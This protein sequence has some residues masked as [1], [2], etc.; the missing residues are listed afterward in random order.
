MLRGKKLRPGT[1]LKFPGANAVVRGGDDRGVFELELTT[2]T[3]LWTWLDDVGQ[4]PLPPYIRRDADA[5]DRHR[6]QTV[7]AEKV[8]AVAAPTA[9]LHFTAD[10]LNR[11]RDKG[12]EIKTITLHVGLGTFL[13]MRV[14]DID[15]HVMHSEHYQVPEETRLALQSKRPVVAVGT[16]VVRAL[17]SYMRDP[18]ATRT[19]IFIRPGFEY[20]CVDGLLTNFHLPE[21]TLLMLVSAFAGYDTIFSAYRQAVDAQMRF[22]SYGDA[23]LLRR[24]N[25]R[26]T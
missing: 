21:S 22:F 24:R 12:V 19:D 15:E 1:D 9:G 18:D 6:Y 10:L 16:T 20:R 7:F 4:I 11:L 13:P 2:S 25:G 3:D 17:E 5:G 26:W 14:D 8:G 23:M